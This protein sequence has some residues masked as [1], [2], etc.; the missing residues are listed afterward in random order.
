MGRLLSRLFPCVPFLHFPKSHTLRTSFPALFQVACPLEGKNSSEKKSLGI[1]LSLPL[2]EKVVVP[3][4]FRSLTRKLCGTPHLPPFFR[5]Q[6]VQRAIQDDN[7]FS[8]SLSRCCSLPPSQNGGA[9][10]N[11]NTHFQHSFVVALW[12]QKNR[13][14]TPMGTHGDAENKRHYYTPC[15]FSSAFSLPIWR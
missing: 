11:I 4:S 7:G 5:T 10:R 6:C 1:S 13:N 3:F 8:A 2:F 12:A 15:H 9:A 14:S